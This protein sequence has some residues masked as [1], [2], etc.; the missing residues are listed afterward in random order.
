[1]HIE[2]LGS[3]TVPSGLKHNGGESIEALIIY[4]VIMAIVI[5]L[6]LVL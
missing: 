6:G 3:V 2:Q 5:G 4:C 1:M